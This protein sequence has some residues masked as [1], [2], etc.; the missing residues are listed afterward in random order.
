MEWFGRAWRC[1]GA[2]VPSL[3]SSFGA[4]LFPSSS[5]PPALSPG[6]GILHVLDP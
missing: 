6:T 1:R 3:P 5:P 4:P 2:D